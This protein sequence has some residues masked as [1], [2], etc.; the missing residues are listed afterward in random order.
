MS[1]TPDPPLDWLHTQLEELRLWRHSMNKAHE[2]D[3]RLAEQIARH[4]AWL[5]DRLDKLRKKA[6]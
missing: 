5:E 6:A 2:P 3:I 1:D 4:E